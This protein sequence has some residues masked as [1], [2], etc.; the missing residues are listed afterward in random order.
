[1]TLQGGRKRRP[2]VD[3]ELALA[4]ACIVLALALLAVLVLAVVALVT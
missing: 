3:P 4:A 1:V 2:Y